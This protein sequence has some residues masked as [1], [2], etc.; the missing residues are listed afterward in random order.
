MGLTFDE[1]KQ[2][3]E[4]REFKEFRLYSKVINQLSNFYNDKD[5][6]FFYPRNVYNNKETE[7][8]FFLN[9]SYLEVKIDTQSI[10]TLNQYYCKVVN[11]ALVIPGY[12]HGEYELRILLDNGTDLKMKSIDD[13]NDDWSSEYNKALKELY[14]LI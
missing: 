8:I 14:K 3:V 7:L 1:F 12:E 9:D 11:K 2:F 13:S 6:K 10:I 4:K 5:F